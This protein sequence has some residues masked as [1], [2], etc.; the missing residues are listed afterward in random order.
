MKYQN[1]IFI[2]SMLIVLI[3]FNIN[4]TKSEIINEYNDELTNYYKTIYE[5]KQENQI[6][7]KFNNNDPSCETC[8]PYTHFKKYNTSS[9]MSCKLLYP[10][11]EYCFV[12]GCEIC[13]KGYKLF[14]DMFR[15]PLCQ[16]DN[17]DTKCF[18][19]VNWIS[20][21]NITNN[22]CLTT[23]FSD[24]EDS[25][26]STSW[27]SILMIIIAFIISS[28]ILGYIF[29]IKKR[30]LIIS[31]SSF[32]NVS[33]NFC[34]MCGKHPKK[35]RP[36]QENN[37]ITNV[38]NNAILEGL[39]V[40]NE[41]SDNNY[42]SENNNNNNLNLEVNNNT[43]RNRIINDSE[44]NMVNNDYKLNCDGFLCEEC[45][46][47][48][49]L[50]LKSGNYPKCKFCKLTIIWYINEDNFTDSK[51]SENSIKVNDNI[52]TNNVFSEENKSEVK[53]SNDIVKI[54]KISREYEKNDKEK[55]VNNN[56]EENNNDTDKKEKISDEKVINGNIK[57]DEKMDSANLEIC[58]V[59]MKLKPDAV[60]PCHYRPKHKLHRHCLAMY[61]KKNEGDK[62]MN[63]PIC[64][65]EI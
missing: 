48:A 21:F 14:F 28:I 41:N 31:P 8:L 40:E 62:E 25:D 49:E 36:I 23:K 16:L 9:C 50:N 37:V 53:Q 54:S 12:N 2:F 58:A 39:I 64:R 51:N 46:I 38:N 63:C 3:I 35:E 19:N 29:C 52:K 17:D 65:G 24:K 13:A 61:Y 5:Y 27:F 57:L 33:H 26:K 30:N 22:S 59:C 11:C 43:N 7:C 60:I 55:E 45:E 20:R 4:A 47:E 15:N 56:T 32:V 18:G 44:R 1:L 10:D 42:I 34:S 6:N